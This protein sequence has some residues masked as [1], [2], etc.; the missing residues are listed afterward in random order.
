MKYTAVALTALLTLVLSVGGSANPPSVWELVWSDEFNK[1][2]PP[3]P[4]NWT[5]ENGFKRNEE[6]QWYQA[7]NAWCENGRLIIEGRRERRK[8]PNYCLLYTSP[9]P[10][11]S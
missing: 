2:G 6:D 4:R 9:S 10:R 5:F 7:R 3:D 11:D 8:N 1:N